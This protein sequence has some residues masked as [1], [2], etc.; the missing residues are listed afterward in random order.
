MTDNM[1]MADRTAAG[2]NSLAT[3]ATASAG[4][5]ITAM[6]QDGT[7]AFNV[8]KPFSQPICLIP[9]TWI[10]GT[11][12]IPEIGSLV[13]KLCMGDRLRLERDGDNYYDLWSIRIFDKSGNR[14]G[15]IRADVN[16]IPARLMD[17]GK[18]LYAEIVDIELRGSWW[19]IS[20][21]VWLDD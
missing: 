19:K 10:A 15:F 7:G 2:E 11:T 13:E 6:H 16:E 17:G 3:F 12:H 18:H 5:I 8:P 1:T 14:L 4:A 9:D 21:G 20:I